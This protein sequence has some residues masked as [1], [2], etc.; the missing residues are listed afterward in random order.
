MALI[1][2]YSHVPAL[3]LILQNMVATLRTYDQAV[4]DGLDSSLLEGQPV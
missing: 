1:S 2:L 3:Q 4:K